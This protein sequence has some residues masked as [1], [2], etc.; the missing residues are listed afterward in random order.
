MLHERPEKLVSQTFYLL[1]C[2]G[3]I[4]CTTAPMRS[5]LSSKFKLIELPQ[6]EKI[7]DE[8]LSD[9]R[10]IVSQKSL[11]MLGEAIHMTS[12]LST[13]RSSLIRSLNRHSGFNFVFFEGSP[14]EFWIANDE[15]LDSPKNA[16]AVTA[17]Q[18]TALF[19]LWQSREIRSLIDYGLS[20]LKEGEGSSLYFSSYDVQIG[21]GMAFLTGAKKIF[22][23]LISRL[24]SK[25]VQWSDAEKNKL[26]QLEGL[27]L[28][29][30]KKFP[31][32]EEQYL[33][34]LEAIKILDNKIQK[35]IAK[36]SKHPKNH[37]Q[38]LTFIPESLK[39]S[40]DFC[41]DAN[42][43]Q[44]DYVEIR[45]Q[46]SARQF[47]SMLRTFKKKSIVWA[48]NG[49]VRKSKKAPMS[50]GAYL[51]EANPNSIFAIAFT[52][53][54]GSAL[55]FMDA[56]GNEFEP[57]VKALQHVENSTLEH[58]LSQLSSHDLFVLLDEGSSLFSPMETTRMETDFSV[59]IDPFN[60]FDAFYMVQRVSPP[61]FKN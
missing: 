61:K 34:S 43:S 53:K 16:Q 3:L 32:N 14:I 26:S 9:I 17:F 15:Y 40:L 8:D 24:E 5:H 33:S 38:A 21:Q 19:P 37:L 51:H 29:K 59:P 35:A 6:A 13:A 47:Q 46:W 41:L 44:R 4:S 57:R 2:I 23:S 55:A 31:S 20:T 36:S 58:K 22:L 52:A 10:A 60:D 50:F 54:D 28:C 49:H 18:R 45:D 30:R 1:L 25:G 27:A 11:V 12:E 39:Y 42:S 48:H 56:Q 7:K